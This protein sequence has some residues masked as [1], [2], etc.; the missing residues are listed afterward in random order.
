MAEPQI[1]FED[2][3][4]YERMMGVWSR[5]AGEVF[6][7]WVK[8][9]SGLRVID[10]GC[11]NGAFTELLVK[12]CAPAEVKGIDPSEGQ[13]AFARTRPGARGAEFLQG[14]A[15]ALPFAEDSF[16]ASVM[17]LVIFFVP[18]P[19]K[20]VSEMVRIV[21]PGGIVATYA[22]DMLGGGFP[23][24]QIR[25]EMRAMG[26]TPPVPPSAAASR[27]D[28]LRELWANAGLENIETRE[29]SVER[30]FANFDEY[31]TINLLGSSIG[32][33]VAAMASGDAERLK[34][35]VLERLP[36]DSDGR[37]TCAGRANAVKGCLPK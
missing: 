23:Q 17:A 20:G 8:L 5:L 6:L 35:G 24:E 11:G 10:I 1:K 32:P 21:S 9:P 30:T 12:R 7:D 3:A 31:W 13:L 37:I 22:W 28:A 29:I 26:L 33:M 16:D 19:V 4:S 15:M 27:M 36:V 34:R 18:D 14:N 2:G 25:S